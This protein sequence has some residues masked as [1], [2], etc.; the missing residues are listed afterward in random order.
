MAW[1]IALTAFG[2]I[3]LVLWELMRAKQNP[4]LR[5]LRGDRQPVLTSTSQ[6]EENATRRIMWPAAVGLG[7]AF[8]RFLPSM[9][10]RD[11]GQMLVRANSRRTV[12]EFI[13]AWGVS[14]ILGGLLF[15]V[16]VRSNNQLSPTFV[17][18]FG[19]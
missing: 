10:L 16:L 2:S 17:L 12:G 19:S 7:H 18:M 13:L 14:A 4:V 5:R 6:L 11:L 1:V 15:Q 8:A 3:T 9:L